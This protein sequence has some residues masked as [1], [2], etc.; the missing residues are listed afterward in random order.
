MIGTA[1]L[2]QEMIK[3]GKMENNLELALKIIDVLNEFREKEK[4]KKILMFEEKQKKIEKEKLEKEQNNK[5][6]DINLIPIDYKERNIELTEDDFNN[7]QKIEIAANIIKGSYISY[8]R[9]I[10]TMFYLE[11]E[12]CYRN[13][14]QTINNFQ[15]MNKSVNKMDKNDLQKLSKTYSDIYFYLKGE[16]RRVYIDR[17]GV[18]LEIEFQAPTQR[19]IKFT[20]RMI[21]S[22]LIILTDDNFEKYLLTTVYYNPYLDKKI[23]DNQR[24]R[25]KSIRMPKHPYYRVQLS[26]VN[27]NPQSFVFL[28]QN[29]KDLQIFESKA[30]F[31]SYVHIMKR[32]KEINIPDL[33]F[34]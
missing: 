18:I 30:Y 26:L 17:D 13:L 33:P 34:R 20:K 19:I 14:R 12:D 6:N 27:I 7:R 2:I 24:M 1:Y 10:N 15:S 11:Y 16:I 31:E 9:Y 22:S 25:K 23:K 32:L 29:R 5:N 4:H 21:T 8:E 28:L 3:N